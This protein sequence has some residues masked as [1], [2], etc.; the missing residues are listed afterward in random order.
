M[1]KV[2]LGLDP[3]YEGGMSVI[4]YAG[5]IIE[6]RPMPLIKTF[7]DYKERKNKKTGKIHLIKRYNKEIDIYAIAYIVRLCC[8]GSTSDVWYNYVIA[9]I[10]H[11]HAMPKQGTTSMFNFG[12]GY[13]ELKGFLKVLP[14]EFY[15]V[16]PTKWKNYFFKT[17]Y[18]KK[19]KR[20][21]Y[22][23]CLADKKAVAMYAKSVTGFHFKTSDTSTILNDGMAESY[24]LAEYGRRNLDEYTSK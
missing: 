20:A 18:D 1:R 11:V 24:L 13:G 7:K 9:F 15:K 16:S 2:I 6:S 22:S 8:D 23:I 21:I 17:G 5:N 12:E 19:R 10:E 4:D 3:G 14:I